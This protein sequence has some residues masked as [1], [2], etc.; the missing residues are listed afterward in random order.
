MNKLKLVVLFFWV[1][2]CSTAKDQPLVNAHAHNDYEHRSPLFGALENKFI[3][4]EVDVHLIDDNLYVS[5]D[6]PISKDLTKTLEALYLKPLL[7]RVDKNKGEVYTG[8]EGYF[9][10]MIDIK[11]EAALSYSVLKNILKDY[12]SIISSVVNGVEEK[13]KPIKIVVTGM[14]GR[15]FRKILADEPKLVSIDGRLAELGKGISKEI[16]P[17]ISENYNNHLSFSGEG[18]PSK[19]D[20]NTIARIVGA[21]HSEGKMLRFWASKDN[22]QVWEF[23]LRNN[24]DLINTDS[25]VQFR[26]YIRNRTN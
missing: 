23:L 10:L 13:G 16:M 2:G 9:Y 8:Y 14:K 24:V 11:T 7:N 1:L 6:T 21:T 18:K 12:H 20:L 17:F 15:P 3:S 26:K 22:P 4:V 25:L 19:K 5:H